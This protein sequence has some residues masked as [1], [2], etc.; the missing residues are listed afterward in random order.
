MVIRLALVDGVAVAVPTDEAGVGWPPDP[1]APPP[2]AVELELSVVTDDGV[3][4]PRAHGSG[5]DREPLRVCNLNG[6]TACSRPLLA[7]G[8]DDDPFGIGTGGV[9]GMVGIR[10]SRF[11]SIV[12]H[13]K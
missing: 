3:S 5:A 12:G 2:V 11:T 10:G 9:G 13:F 1:V 7:A 6:G 8:S 4:A